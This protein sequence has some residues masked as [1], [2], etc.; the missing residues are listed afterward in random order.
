[1]KKENEKETRLKKVE[2]KEKK[3]KT[4]E[5]SS[6]DNCE[7]LIV[8]LNTKALLLNSKKRMK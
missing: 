6:Q 1:M 4:L 3:I 5:R 7:Y 2:R 8:L